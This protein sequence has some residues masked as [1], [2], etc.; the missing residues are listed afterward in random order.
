MSF[1]LNREDK[2]NFNTV[3]RMSKSM[4][5]APT[6]HLNTIMRKSKWL[7]LLVGALLL[8]ACQSAPSVV[9]K[10]GG[11]VEEALLFPKPD[12]SVELKGSPAER[13]LALLSSQTFKEVLPL[14]ETQITQEQLEEIKAFTDALVKEHGAKTQK[15]KHQVL[16]KWIGQ[17]VKYGHVYDPKIPDYNSAYTTFKYKNAICQGYSNLLKVFCHTQGISAPVVNGLARFNTLGNPFGHAWNYVLLDGRWYVSD[18]T[19]KIFYEAD[20]KGR[21]NFLL[22]ERLDF[23]LWEDDSMVYVYEKREITVLRVKAPSSGNKLVVP[24]SVGGF[25]IS[26]FNPESLPKTVQEVYLG[27]NIKY[28]GTEDSRRLIDSG[29]EI[30]KISVDPTNPHLE[31]YKGTIYPKGQGATDVPI[32]IPAR[33]K[34]IQLKPLK[35]VGKNVINAHQGVEVLTFAEGTEVIEDYA[36]EACPQLVTVHLPKSVKS[37]S[38]QAFY[39]CNPALKVVRP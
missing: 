12:N 22:P 6:N 15:E 34:H 39:N 37:V 36:V 32:L 4:R 5:S 27:S 18:A 10:E 31:E 8:N 21:F 7:M 29:G 19:N 33:L 14:G 9:E 16:F 1:L 30:S 25:Q 38:P 17:H 2:I 11:D 3:P 23:N 13:V 20:D 28:I 24:Y 26:N 35:V